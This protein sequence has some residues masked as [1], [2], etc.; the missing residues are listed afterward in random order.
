MREAFTFQLSSSE[1]KMCVIMLAVLVVW[2]LLG[3]SWAIGILSVII[4]LALLQ[5]NHEVK[6]NYSQCYGRRNGT[7]VKRTVGPKARVATCTPEQKAGAS[8]QIATGNDGSKAVIVD[9][10]SQA[11]FCDDTVRQNF[12]YNNPPPGFSSPFGLVSRQPLTASQFANVNAPMAVNQKVDMKRAQYP[13]EMN[14]AFEA[15]PMSNNQ[16]L[17]GP[18]NPKTFIPPVITPQPYVQEAWAANNLIGFSQINY[19]TQQ[20]L[21]QSGF[22]PADAEC[23][24]GGVFIPPDNRLYPVYKANAFGDDDSRCTRE[25]ETRRPYSSKRR[26]QHQQQ[27]GELIENFAEPTSDASCGGGSCG[28]PDDS[29]QAW[30]DG[31][32]ERNRVSRTC[33]NDIPS[34]SVNY[35]CGFDPSRPLRSGLPTNYSIGPCQDNS[36]ML[37]YNTNTFTSIVAPGVYTTSQITENPQSNMG[38]SFQQQFPPTSLDFDSNGNIHYTAHDPNIIENAWLKKDDGECNPQIDVSNVYDPRHTGYGTS[39]RAYLN[40]ELGQPRFNYSDV[41]AIKM[42]NY[43]TR[44]NVDHLPF[45]DKYGPM[46][47]GGARGNEFNAKIRSLANDAFMRNAVGFR[48]DLQERL[49]RKKN[50][51]SWQRRVA[52]ISTHSQRMGGGMG[53]K[54]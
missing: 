46:P 19:E 9:R 15:S 40:Q 8:M 20:D 51:E 53:C 18:P 22:V 45:A 6:E 37:E 48:T 54:A 38:I 11:T 29:W 10:P 1:L 34:G 44:S 32:D 50:A 4:L 42:P 23:F 12:N 25:V 21:Y 30:I 36:G 14:G 7:G 5:M 47:K 24:E 3:G 35:D 2:F 26:Q 13:S 28:G 52:P 31:D 16:T 27:Y 49:M 17:A 33:G 41:D 43:I 39:Y